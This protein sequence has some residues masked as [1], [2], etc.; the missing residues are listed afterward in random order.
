MDDYDDKITQLPIRSVTC[1]LWFSSNHFKRTT[2]NNL[3]YIN[4]SL[5]SKFLCRHSLTANTTYYLQMLFK[6][7]YLSYGKDK[8][9]LNRIIN[10]INDN[11]K[12]KNKRIT[13]KDIGIRTVN[14]NEI[15]YDIDL[16]Y[17]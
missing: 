16:L 14:H 4:I 7:Y 9:G 2:K 11:F 1:P 10:T 5:Y 6:H 8:S 12:T 17:T 15:V 13:V 3:Y